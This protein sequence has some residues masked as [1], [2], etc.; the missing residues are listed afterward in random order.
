MKGRCT[1]KKYSI[2][3]SQSKFNRNDTIIC[4]HRDE[5]FFQKISLKLL[6]KIHTYY[7]M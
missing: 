2:H 1:F 3:Y 4:K 7:I 6:Q 5:N